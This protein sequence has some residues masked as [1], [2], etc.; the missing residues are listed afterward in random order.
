MNSF[1]TTGELE[2]ELKRQKNL[3]S[4]R[5]EIEM[6]GLKRARLRKEIKLQKLR[7]KH[8]RFLRFS[9]G[10]TKL[11]KMAGKGIMKVSKNIS[12]AERKESLKNKPKKSS[13][14]DVANIIP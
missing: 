4:A 10:I 14:R 6:E 7:N 2:R 11:G 1:K 9:M 12:E 8:P 13:I 3:A 5:T